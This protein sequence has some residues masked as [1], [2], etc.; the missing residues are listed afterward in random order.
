MPQVSL[1]EEDHIAEA[2]TPT[3]EAIAHGEVGHRALVAARQ[4]RAPSREGIAKN[5]RKWQS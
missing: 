5:R 2:I 4:G 1:A 3:R